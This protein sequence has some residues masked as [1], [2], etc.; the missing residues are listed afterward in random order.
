MH[1]LTTSVLI[2][3]TELASDTPQ[4][5]RR[6]GVNFNG[7]FLAGCCWQKTHAIATSSRLNKILFMWSFG[8]FKFLVKMISSLERFSRKNLPDLLPVCLIFMCLIHV[9]NKNSF[10]DIHKS[11]MDIHD[12]N[13][14]SIIGSFYG[15]PSGLGRVPDLRVRVQVLLICVS[16]STSP[17]TWLLHE[18]EYWLTSTSLWVLAY[19]LHSI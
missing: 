12:W 9:L 3:G 11:T 8:I 19:D 7:P 2:A 18:Y 14:D 6:I 5:F 15:S 1:L 16:T 10:M 13:I 17:S 4:C